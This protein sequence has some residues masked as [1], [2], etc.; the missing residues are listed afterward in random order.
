MPGYLDQIMADYDASAFVDPD[1]FGEEIIYKPLAGA[2]VKINAIVVRDPPEFRSVAGASR[3][4]KMLVYVRNHRTKGR[5]SINTGG[6]RVHVAYRIGSCAED[7][8]VTGPVTQ[9]AGMWQLELS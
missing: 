8:S 4:P 9:D 6:D 3:R 2:P 1:V 5:E 7:F